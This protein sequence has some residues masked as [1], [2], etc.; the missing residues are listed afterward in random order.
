MLSTLVQLRLEHPSPGWLLASGSLTSQGS[1]R[2]SALLDWRICLFRST[3][4][5][6]RRVVAFVIVTL[7][8]MMMMMKGMKKRRHNISL[9]DRRC[10]CCRRRHHHRRRRRRNCRCCGCGRGRVAARWAALVKNTLSAPCSFACS[11]RRYESDQ[12]GR[13]RRRRRKSVWRGDLCGPIA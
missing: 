3:L 11:P 9:V 1:S 4:S 8:M 12:A 5:A 13:R 7:A 6:S 2:C 10:C